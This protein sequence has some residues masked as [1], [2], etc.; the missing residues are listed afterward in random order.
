MTDQSKPHKLCCFVDESGQDT[1]GAWFIVSVII[2]QSEYAALEIELE[3]IEERSGKGKV[4]WRDAKDAARVEYIAQIL[5]LEALAGKLTYTLFH[6]TQ[7]YLTC[8]V[9]AVAQ[10]VTYYS[11]EARVTVFVDGLPKSKIKWFGTELRRRRI[12]VRKVRGVRR[13]E[14][15]SLMRLADALCGFVRAAL[16]GRTELEQMLKEAKDQGVVKEL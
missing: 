15:S 14:S 11:A 8:T 13:E 6:G 16:T 4:K 7:D 12:A 9:D 5:A 3:R 10:S 2:T 1:K